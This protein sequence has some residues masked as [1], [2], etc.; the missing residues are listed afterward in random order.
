M[1]ET[2]N[3]FKYRFIESKFIDI[4]QEILREIH[5]LLVVIRRKPR[6]KG[7]PDIVEEF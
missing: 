1:G 5:T 4:S 2:I 3:L 6:K 7:R